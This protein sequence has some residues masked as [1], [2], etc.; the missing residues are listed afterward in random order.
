MIRRGVHKSVQALEQDIRTWI[1]TW[2]DDPETFV[3]KKTA[4]EILTLWPATFNA[5]QG[6][7]QSTELSSEL[8]TRDT[9]PGL[10]LCPSGD[11]SQA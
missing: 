4:D 1:T 7:R 2:N 8:K 3:W 5:L 10:A 11:A 9:S 6:T